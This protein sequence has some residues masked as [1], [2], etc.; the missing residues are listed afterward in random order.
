MPIRAPPAAYRRGV[1]SSF[2]FTSTRNT[3][4]PVLVEACKFGDASCS[5]PGYAVQ[6]PYMQLGTDSVA[7]VSVSVSR[8]GLEQSE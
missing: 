7:K 1:T 5:A 8:A 2:Y 4:Q 3:W 6:W